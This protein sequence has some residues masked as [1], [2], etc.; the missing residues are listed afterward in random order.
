MD[1]FRLQAAQPLPASCRFAGFIL[2][3]TRGTL[4][5]PDGSEAALRPKTVELLLHLAQRAGEVVS[6]EM[7][8]EAI[9][10][11][12]FVS[13]DSI[14]QCVTEIRRALGEAGSA[15]LRTLPKRGYLLA[16]EMEC[17]LPA[18][19]APMPVPAATGRPSLLVLPFANLS[20]DPAQDYFADGMTEELTTALSRI[21]WFFVIARNSA[22]T[23]KGRAVDLRLIGRDLGVRYV[24]EG[25]V[26]KA[27]GRVRVECRLAEADTARQVWTRRIEGDLSDIFG[28]QDCVAECVAGA[29]EP[30]LRAAEMARSRAKPTDRM[31]AYDFYLRALPHRYARTRAGTEEALG[32]LRTAM[33]LDPG[34]GLAKALAAFCH[35]L[36]AVQGWEGPGDRALGISLAREVVRSAPDEP[37]ALHCAARALVYLD[38]DHAGAWSA[39]ERAIALNPNSAE[40]LNSAGLVCVFAGQPEQA[41]TYFKKALR[42]SPFDTEMADMLLDTSIAH[43]MLG[44]HEQA[45]DHAQRALLE[46]PD[47][48]VGHRQYITALHALGR[49]EDAAAAAQRFRNACPSA[50]RVLATTWRRLYRDHAYAEM[51]VCALREAGLPE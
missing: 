49:R 17:A 41:I 29:I 6:R 36:L 34:F 40:I 16:V 21:R 22:F 51:R 1:Q 19:D 35:T 50:A 46:L 44:Q 9:W 13:D 33:D 10:P 31:D 15:L 42:L 18:D 23:Y 27:G 5:R 7:L 20:G 8:L 30:S 4:R 45:L 26:R 11:G 25:S 43:T 12:T 2:E 38:Y 32:L 14:T 48:A 47:W 37:A 39:I 24:V 3:P 28:L